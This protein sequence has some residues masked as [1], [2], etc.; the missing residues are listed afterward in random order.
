MK[1]SILKTE[2]SVQQ[3]NCTACLTVLTCIGSDDDPVGS[4]HVAIKIALQQIA[5]W[6]GSPLLGRTVPLQEMSHNIYE[7][8]LVTVTSLDKFGD[9]TVPKIMFS[10]ASYSC[11]R[12][13]SCQTKCFAAERVG[14]LTP[15]HLFYVCPESLLTFLLSHYSD[16]ACVW[17]NV[18]KQNTLVI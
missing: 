8:I 9:F 15:E 14:I 13:S 17:R 11:F 1:H 6:R 4:K 12:S 7:Y 18:V 2:I 16:R 5:W 10:G 3:I